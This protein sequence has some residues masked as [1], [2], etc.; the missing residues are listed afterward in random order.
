MRVVSLDQLI[1]RLEDRFG[2]DDPFVLALRVAEDLNRAG[3][4]DAG[5]EEVTRAYELL[6][7]YSPAARQEI[8]DE[9]TN[10]LFGGDGS[11]DAEGL[12][13]MPPAGNA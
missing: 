8:L 11:D 2:S 5:A 13:H 6:D 12:R 10:W 1:D 9:M 7:A 3:L 4:D